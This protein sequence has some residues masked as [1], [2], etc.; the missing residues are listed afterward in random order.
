MAEGVDMN[1]ENVHFGVAGN[2]FSIAKTM[3]LDGSAQ[4][5]RPTFSG[6]KISSLFHLP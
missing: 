1:E 3:P 6:K 2:Y 4:K 5:A